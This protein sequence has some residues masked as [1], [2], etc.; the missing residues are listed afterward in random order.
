VEP[1]SGRLIVVVDSRRRMR[2][3][4]RTRGWVDVMLV[5]QWNRGRVDVM[6]VNRRLQV[7][8][9]AEAG[10]GTS[11]KRGRR[12]RRVD[13]VSKCRGVQASLT[14]KEGCGI[15]R[16]RRRRVDSVAKA[17][18]A[19]AHMRLLLQVVCTCCCR[20]SVP[21]IRPEGRRSRNK[22]SVCPLTLKNKSK[23]KQQKK[24]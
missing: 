8:S 16:G 21:V 2:G 23:H 12:R 24:W 10:H 14:A 4:R 18:T 1:G 22:D 3:R 17:T 9:T 19:T 5:N 15:K 13:T 11:V 6:L 7:S 20:T